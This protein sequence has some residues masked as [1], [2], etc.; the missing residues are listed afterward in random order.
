MRGTIIPKIDKYFVLAFEENI[1][2][3]KE[4]SESWEEEFKRIKEDPKYFFDNYFKVI[5]E[6][7]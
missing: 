6:G 7:E 1:H 3:G 4:P 2:K 5:K